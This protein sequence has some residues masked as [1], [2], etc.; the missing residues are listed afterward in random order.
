MAAVRVGLIGDDFILNPSYREIEKGDLDIVVAGSPEG[1]VM[2]EAGNQLS[3]QDTIEAI[4]FGYEAVSELIK[5]QEDL[6]KD[7]EAKES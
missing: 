1:I 2:I 3:E 5:A 4:D 7:L 6:L